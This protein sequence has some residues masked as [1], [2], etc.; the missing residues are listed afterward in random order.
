M[1]LKTLAQLIA[2]MCVTG[3][4]V[5]QAPGE[6]MARVEIT[7]SSIKRIAKEGALPVEVISRKQIEA[8]GI[9]NAEQLIATL[10]INGN[11]SDNLA[12][13]ADVTSGS[14]RGNNGASSANL[15]GQGADSTLV[16]LNGRRV[17]TH[18]MK[19]SAVD[20]N[21]IPFA[22]VE[23]VEVLKDG[24]SAIYGTDAIGGVINFILKK[25]YKGLEAQ[26]F[27]DVTEAGGGN[28][29]R[30]QVTGGVGD[31]Q[32][33]G[34]NVLF[35]L[36]TGENKA[37]NGN[38]RDFVNTFQPDRGVSV[39]T[40]GAPFAN[41]FATS[42]G[43]T[44]FSRGSNTGPVRRGTTQ[45]Y[46]GVSLL[47]L[48][49]GAGCSSVDGMGAY[50]EKLW[51]TPSG[52][53]GCAWDTGRA[54]V[55]QQP[56]KNSNFVTRATMRLGGHEFFAELVGAKTEVAKRFSPNQVS[57]GA[58][59]FPAS[60]FYP[61]TGAAYNEV[62]NALV[63]EFPSIE[64]NRGLPIAYRWR[65]MDCGDRDIATVSKAGRLQLGADGQL[66]K[67]DYK[68]GLTR[69]TSESESTLGN[70]YNYT[71]PLAAAL[72]TGLINPFLKAGEK[73]SQQALDL[74][75]STSAA[76]VVLYGG[77][78][79]LTAF[80]ASLSGE[81]LALPAGPIMAAV[82]TDIR[83]EAYKFNGDLRKLAERRAILNA[84]FDDVNVLPQVSRD[85]R[86]FYAEVLVPVTKE[87]DVTV[88]ARQDHYSGFGNTLNPKVSFRYQ[89]TTQWLFRGS[90]NEGFRAPSFNQLFNG[91]TESTYAGKDL[92][93][94]GKCASGKVDTTKPGCE[95]ITPIVFTGG[96]PKLGPETSKQG[97]VGM[98]FEPSAQFSAN[99][100]IWEVR[101]F[102]T[103]KEVEL[104]M[105]LANYE[106]FKEQFRRDADGKL[107][108][109]DRRWLNTGAA[110]TRG[111]EIGA[112]TNGKL[113]AGN[114][115]AGIDGSYLL[116]KK[117]K[118][119]ESAPYSKDEVGVFS[120]TGDL[121]L[122]WKHTAYVTFARG[123][124]SAMFQN[125]YRSGYTDQVLPGVASGRIV[126]SNYNAKVDPYS[127]FHASLS[128]TGVKNL[129]LTAGIKNLFDKDPPFAI[130][131]DGNTGAGSSWEPRVA[132]PRGRSLTL[133]ANYKFL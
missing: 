16:L 4:A 36:S 45:A 115:A 109:I 58:A 42:L 92:A 64:A 59:T 13:N 67:Y 103:I 93:D 69:A 65:C 83:K 41:V 121:G 28:I 133:M 79:T 107:A 3:Q 91:I 43:N 50:D 88:A 130:T 71:A 89:P 33:Q 123:D 111:I 61:S 106:L 82:G 98:V 120:F 72:G 87:L 27:T 116:K 78:T 85:I 21:S 118:P 38:Q 124:W 6:P 19:G 56:V 128:Y 105:M 11:G 35:A 114:W 48:P 32:E 24:A 46:S 34:F 81:V 37:L 110:I 26:A 73:Q 122:K 2:L 15:R 100:D 55:L 125:V 5:A 127:I 47:D 113:W 9:V 132:D 104:P 77:K 63:A 60:S 12:S 66:G 30:Y 84:P 131:Y 14:Q 10:N 117:S 70:G 96:K 90:Y 31:L 99:M 76:G 57:P 40:R 29:A 126:P 95:S 53:L 74:I 22:A 20:L 86:A 119:L 112:R 129:S 7:G 44:I 18:G 8:Q 80:D 49:G 51:D 97:T 54:A 68:V 17:A 108:V 101:R 1:E 23:R 25:N 102:D 62:F 39:D 52:G 94:P 75:R